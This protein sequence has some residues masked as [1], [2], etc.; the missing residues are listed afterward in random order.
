MTERSHHLNYAS[1]VFSLDLH[2][3]SCQDFRRSNKHALYFT[4]SKQTVQT[5]DLER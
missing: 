1:W 4:V 5:L 2:M 3:F